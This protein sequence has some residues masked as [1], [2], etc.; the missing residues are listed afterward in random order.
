MATLEQKID[1]ILDWIANNDPEY[2]LSIRMRI[3]EALAVASGGVG[4]YDGAD[5]DDMILDLFKDLGAPGNLKGYTYAIA[6]VKI[7]LVDPSSIN[8]IKKDIYATIA[9]RYNVPIPRIE[10]AIR[11]LTD[12]ILDHGNNKIVQDI[13]GNIVSMKTGNMANGTFIAAC[14][15][16]IRRRMK[17]RGF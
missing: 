16:E 13:L 8:A 2:D 9:S 15:Q 1:I 7:V 5:V 12:R 4:V 3:R 10:R 11:T 17:R 6:A 14:A